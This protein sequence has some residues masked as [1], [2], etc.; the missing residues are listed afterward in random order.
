MSI[1][2]KQCI[3]YTICMVMELKCLLILLVSWWVTYISG[4]NLHPLALP[5]LVCLHS[6]QVI[7][8]T[9]TSIRSQSLCLMFFICNNLGRKWTTNFWS[10]FNIFTKGCYLGLSE[11][12]RKCIIGLFSVLVNLF[13]NATPTLFHYKWVLRLVTWC[14]EEVQ[15]SRRWQSDPVL[16]RFKSIRVLIF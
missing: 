5:Q 3:H 10:L 9:F 2:R 16:S 13:W 11:H 7:L 6:A 8:P 4:W 15:I 14:L 12:W 1:E